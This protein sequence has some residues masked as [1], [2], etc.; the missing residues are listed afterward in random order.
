[1][2]SK[3]FDVEIFREVS[4]ILVGTKRVD[5]HKKVELVFNCI[6]QL[7]A[8]GERPEEFVQ[9]VTDPDFIEALKKAVLTAEGAKFEIKKMVRLYDLIRKQRGRY[10]RICNGN[11]RDDDER[12]A[13]AFGNSISAFKLNSVAA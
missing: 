12:A 8:L 10:G 2:E 13:I 3:P 6:K 4:E 7:D 11:P 1:M 9:N 5:P